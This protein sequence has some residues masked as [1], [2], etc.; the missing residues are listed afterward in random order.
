MWRRKCFL[1]KELNEMFVEYIINIRYSNNLV[2]SDKF[3]FKIFGWDDEPCTWAKLEAIFM[4]GVFW[5]TDVVLLEQARKNHFLFCDA[6]VHCYNLTVVN[7]Y[8]SLYDSTLSP[9][10]L[11]IHCRPPPPKGKY[12]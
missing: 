12:A 9:A 10:N 6:K 2:A 7:V 5:K 11:P 3:E 4:Y 8:C 1:R